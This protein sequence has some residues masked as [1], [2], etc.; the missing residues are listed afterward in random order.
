M[1]SL[2]RC[3][4]NQGWTSLDKGKVGEGEV[5]RGFQ[6]REEWFRQGEFVQRWSKCL[7][8]YV[9]SPILSY[10]AEMTVT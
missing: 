9:L 2:R 5:C 4:L 3:Q 8:A 1:I 6:G 10:L 7:S